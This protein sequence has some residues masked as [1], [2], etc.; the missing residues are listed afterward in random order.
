MTQEFECQEERGPSI[1]KKLEKILQD[2][3][4][5]V[6]KKE[7]LEKVVMNTLPP[8][9]F[10]VNPE[11]WR[12]ILLT[13]SVDLRLQEIQKLVLKSGTVVAKIMN[14]LYE[15]KKN[16]TVCRHLNANRTN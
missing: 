5:G 14:L 15:A 16:Q 9:N 11:F 10:L 6:F 7:K 1:L 12:R 2:L 8:K 4:W 3:L 13:K